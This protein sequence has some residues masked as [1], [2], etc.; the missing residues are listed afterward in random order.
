MEPNFNVY[1]ASYITSF[2]VPYDYDSVMHYGRFAFSWNGFPTVVPRVSQLFIYSYQLAGSQAG[3]EVLHYR[4]EFN[5]NKKLQKKGR[6]QPL[7]AK[8]WNHSQV[9]CSEV[10]GG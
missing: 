2:G 3:F 7:S 6:Q 10:N 9:N 5:Q 4:Q 8:G 1:P